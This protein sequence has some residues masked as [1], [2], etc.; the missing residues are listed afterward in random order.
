MR[1]GDLPG[2]TRRNRAVSGALSAVVATA[3]AHQALATPTVG[4]HEEFAGVSTNGWVSGAQVSNP[5]TGG[6]FGAGD[7]YLLVSIP[8]PFPGNLGATAPTS[9]YVGD[10]TAA[11]V[12]QV[13]FWLNDVNAQDTLEV[14]FAL[15]NSFLGNFWQCNTG[16]IPPPHDWAPFVVDLTVP[17][18]FS[19]IGAG[20]ATF[21]SALTSVDRILIRHDKA[22]YEKTPDTIIA[23]FG[24][25]GLLLTNGQVG[26][27]GRGPIAT[28]QPVRLAPP[29]PNP[30]RGAVQL[31]MDSAD[32]GPVTVQVVDPLGRVIRHA[33]LPAGAAGPRTWSWDGAD[34]RG[35]AAAAGYY[36]V[37]AIGAAG[38]TSQPLV[39]IP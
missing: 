31:R 8:G 23:D 26:V 2:S 34:D 14:H 20:T 5:G 35:I 36:R 3:I 13:R 27:G 28:G 21:A 15:G 37:R 32:G 12:T 1:V 16:F 25:D 9:D 18:N 22:P 24:I 6:R 19:F 17:A 10:W 33:A 7:G 38:G 29:A 11:G 30:S 39:R 4:F